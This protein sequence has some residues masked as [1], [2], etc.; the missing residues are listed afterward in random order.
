MSA[1]KDGYNRTYRV[2]A[3]NG[4]THVGQLGTLTAPALFITAQIDP[5]STPEMS[6]RMAEEVQRRQI[7]IMP[8][9]SMGQYL[10]ARSIEPVMRRFLRS[11]LPQE[12][13]NA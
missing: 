5:N 6:R 3:E 7:H 11:P 4:E 1:D 12:P 2:F 9:E 10:A 13:L 8:G